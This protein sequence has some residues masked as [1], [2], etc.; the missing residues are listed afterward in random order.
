MF[1][2]FSQPPA[3]GFQKVSQVQLLR[4]DRQAF[5]RLGETFNGSLKVV[6]GAGKPLDP[7][8]E[9]LENDVSVTTLCYRLQR[10]RVQV[11]RK[12]IQTRW[13]RRDRRPQVQ[14]GRRATSFKKG[15][16]G[17]SKGKN[18]KREQV[19]TGLKGMHSRTPQC[20]QICYGYNLGTCKQGSACPRKHVCAVPG[21]YTNHPQTEHQ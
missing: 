16:K 2:F 15:T 5:V 21:C 7:L 8:I 10:K 17:K 3:P 9:R 14:T 1:A 18:K 20:D 6:P 11:V 4:A 13:T 19:P 12:A